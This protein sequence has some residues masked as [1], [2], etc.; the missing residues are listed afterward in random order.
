MRHWAWVW[1]EAGNASRMAPPAFLVKINRC[2][3]GILVI[4]RHNDCCGDV[5]LMLKGK[6]TVWEEKNGC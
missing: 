3:A 6:N 2:P 1:Q 5:N 4:H